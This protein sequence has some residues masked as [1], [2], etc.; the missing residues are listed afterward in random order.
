MNEARKGICLTA[1]QRRPRGTTMDAKAEALMHA[2]SIH[3]IAIALIHG[4]NMVLQ[5]LLEE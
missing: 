1:R 5:P 3:K 4:L 2:V